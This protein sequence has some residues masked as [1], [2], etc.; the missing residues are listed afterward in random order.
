MWGQPPSA[1][2]RSAAP[3]L[4]ARNETLFIFMWGQL[5]SAV[6]RRVAPQLSART[7]TLFI[8]MWGQ[9]PSA[10]RRSAAPQRD[11]YLHSISVILSEASSNDLT[12]KHSV[13]HPGRSELE[14]A[15]D[16]TPSLSS[17]AKRARTSS[18]WNT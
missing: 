6:R 11:S 14:R 2:R 12:M 18:R 7:E 5:P 4:S 1:V 9:P 13:C 17:W 8:F 3:Q 16:E 10:V 15:P